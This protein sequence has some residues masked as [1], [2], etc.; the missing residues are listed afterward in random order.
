VTTAASIFVHIDVGGVT[1][2]VGTMWA[3][4]GRSTRRTAAATF[5]Y[6]PEWLRDP[7]HF[8][9]EPALT[10]G[11]GRFQTARG[12]ALFG[13]FGDSAPD[14]WGRMLM[15]RAAAQRARETGVAVP[16]LTEADYLLGVS[17][18]S[19]GGALRF[20]TEPRGPF[21]AV[22]SGAD[23]PPVVDLPALLNASDEI[24]E[25][26]GGAA[27]LRLLL[28]PG[29]SL[30]GARPKA[31]VRDH[32]GQ[33]A[34]AKFPSRTDRVSSVLWE[35]VA[36]TLAEHSGLRV[37]QH[38]IVPVGDRPVLVV[39][40]F[41]R[42]HS[43]RVPFLSAMG[44]LGASD[45][46]SHSYLEI[47][48]AIRQHGA[49]AGED[50]RELWRRIVFTILISNTDDHLRNHGFLYDGATRGW[51]LAPL[52]D[53]NPTPRSV[54]PGILTLA[55]DESNTTADLDIALDVAA[56][57][58]IDQREARS[59]AG[60]VGTA[61]HQWADQAR[62]V[63]LSGHEIDEMSSAFTRPGAG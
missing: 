60:A 33:L 42:V 12:R 57:F 6:A 45:N 22:P 2:R 38:R 50:L 63:G 14:R 10:I 53:V 25:H 27:A 49:A 36:L 4:R 46:E 16:R 31:S 7:A 21:V 17:D 26:D 15:D 19:R 61:V 39:Q 56:Y 8:S 32:D 48:D 23:V 52:Y 58:D 62:A 5:E 41:D 55:I 29:S 3:H 13:A 37:E 9:L 43:R 40:R 47:A 59:I 20:A 54:R 44:M 1:T 28:A 11:P 51:R 18:E 24:A 35:S 30:G 34:I